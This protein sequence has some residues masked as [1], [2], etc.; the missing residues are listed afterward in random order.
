[1]SNL[2]GSAYVVVP[3]VTPAPA[4]MVLHSWWGLND[5]VR[6][7]CDALAEAGF[8][9]MAPDL[10]AVSS[11]HLVC[12]SCNP[13]ARRTDPLL[14]QEEGDVGGGEH[15]FYEHVQH[16]QDLHVCNSPGRL[17]ARQRDSKHPGAF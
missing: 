4:V 6:A 8:V 9:A 5:D 12:H 11:V 10:L 3:D 17:M 2:A 7:V 16:L 13:I 14:C 1:M 15:R